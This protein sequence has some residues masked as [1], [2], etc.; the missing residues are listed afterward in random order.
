MTLFCALSLY[1]LEYC[2][3]LFAVSLIPW[4]PVIVNTDKYLA[5]SIVI[6]PAVE[7]AAA[8]GNCVDDLLLGLDLPSNYARELLTND[9]NNIEHSLLTTNSQYRFV[10]NVQKVFDDPAIALQLG[11]RADFA[12]LGMLGMVMISASTMAEA[13]A[14]GGRYSHIGGTLASIQHI[15]IDGSPAYDVEVPALDRELTRYLIE[16]QFTSFISYTRELIHG[17]DIDVPLLRQ[18][19]FKHARPNHASA[20]DAYFDCDIEFGADANQFILNPALADV[21]PAYANTQACTV[22]RSI[23]QSVMDELREQDELLQALQTL[24]ADQSH[25]FLKL[26]DCATTLGMGARALRRRL[27]DLDTSFSQVVAGVKCEQAYALLRKDDLS[28]QDVAELLGYSEVA[29]FRRAFKSWTGLSPSA[30]REQLP[31]PI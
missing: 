18:V 21:V 23:C 25:A 27:L 7:L 16:E 2:V 4:L 6:L 26:D 8:R 10:S 24:I 17:R 12:A 22:C 1:S 9:A 30:F 31:T 11:S 28:V 29:N 3:L 19:R 5:S 13:L 20:Y 15:Q 14:L